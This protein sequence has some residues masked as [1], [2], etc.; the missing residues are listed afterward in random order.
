MHWVVAVV[1][2]VV[3]ACTPRLP[4]E[5]GSNGEIVLRN[6]NSPSKKP[7]WNVRYYRPFKP[8]DSSTWRLKV[9]GLVEKPGEFSLQEIL[10]HSMP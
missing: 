10:L 2:V 8:V 9:E 4:G 3:A 7:K 5:T 1:G 6:E